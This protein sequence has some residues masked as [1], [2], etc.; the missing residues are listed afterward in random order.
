MFFQRIRTRLVAGA[1]R[2]PK[3]KLLRKLIRQQDGVAAVEFSFVAVPFFLLLFAILQTG[4]VFFGGQALETAVADSAR[5]IMTGQAQ[6]QNLTQSTFKNEVCKRIYGLF[7]CNKMYVDVRTF[8]NF[9]YSLP[10]PLDSDG[11]IQ[12]NMVYQPGNA[13]DIVVV[14]LIYPMSVYVK[15]LGLANMAGDQRMLVAT[16]V[17]R[18]E[19]YE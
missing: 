1:L 12:N 15:L 13:G 18:N 2:L 4:I 16:A 10:S 5:L 17:F 8:T 11:N 19:P 6:T 3:H 7:D 9:S 14:R